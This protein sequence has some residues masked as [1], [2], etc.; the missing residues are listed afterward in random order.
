MVA[1]HEVAVDGVTGA[2]LAPLDGTGAVLLWQKEGK[3]YMLKGDG[4][5]DELLQI[6][7]VE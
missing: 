2:A 5:V 6:L 1:F 3:M 7:T 4:S